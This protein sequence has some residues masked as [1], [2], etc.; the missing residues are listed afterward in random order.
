M[1]DVHMKREDGKISAKILIIIIIM[2]LIIV[3]GISMVLL[4]STGKIKIEGNDSEIGNQN[5]KDGYADQMK[6][7]TED[8]N[9]Y[10]FI[11]EKGNLIKLSKDIAGESDDFKLFTAYNYTFYN[12]CMAIRKDGK[13]SII[14][15]AGNTVFESDSTISEIINTKESTVYEFRDNGKYGVIDAKGNIIVPAENN[16]Q[17]KS[18][19][20]K[21]MYTY[22][23]NSDKTGEAYILKIFNN[24]GKKV[25][26]GESTTSTLWGAEQMKTK[27]GIYACVINK[28][29]NL[30]IVLNLNSGEIIQTI[31]KTTNKDV[32][33]YDGGSALGVEWYEKSENNSEPEKKIN[34]YWVGDDGKISNK[35]SITD[36]IRIIRTN[37]TNF[38]IIKTDSK[39]YILNKKGD[40]I[41]NTK[42]D[43]SQMVY[44][45]KKDNETRSIFTERIDKKQ[46]KT[47]NENIETILET[48]ASKNGNKYILANKILYKY[49]GT[50]YMEN[51]EE[52]Y[53]IYNLLDIIKTSDKTIIEN[54]EG[55]QVE[56]DV[57]FE[58]S[59]K[60]DVLDENT[61]VLATNKILSIIDT[62]ELTIK[63]LDLSSY[64]YVFVEKGYIYVTDKTKKIYY[65]KN[66]EI[67]FEI[68][69]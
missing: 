16:E 36:K 48:G 44:N 32:E 39:N 6:Y 31:E 54:A 45:N 62:K 9:T 46:Y 63:T 12:S 4:L 25:Y 61:I 19:N 23:N 41:Y 52:Y 69:K 58:V 55:K 60:A 26:E 34:Y 38:N 10:I 50:K 1:M 40:I 30:D 56:Q 29:K 15:F 65:N 27:S 2:L 7:I 22:E 20:E 53:S 35:L 33:L 18:L 24:E 11:D 43:I 66:G 64:E 59:D 14:D 67:I 21:F 47:L 13:Y 42:N 37:S 8:D 49:D 17:I 51:V 3:A 57:N 68:E 5:E 28:S